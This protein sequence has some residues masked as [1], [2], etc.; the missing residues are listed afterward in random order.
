MR[1]GSVA[2]AYEYANRV[3]VLHDHPAGELSPHL[4]A[5][6]PVCAEKLRPPRGWTLEDRRST[7]PLFGERAEDVLAVTTIEEPVAAE[8][9][10]LGKQLFFGSS[11]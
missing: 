1:P 4:Y 5:L 9:G 2:L 10:S 7:P 6:C 11:F 3:A 8:A